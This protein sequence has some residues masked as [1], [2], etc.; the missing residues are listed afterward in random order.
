MIPVSRPVASFL[1]LEDYLI[2]L[3]FTVAWASAIYIAYTS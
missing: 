2:A 1:Y 3:F